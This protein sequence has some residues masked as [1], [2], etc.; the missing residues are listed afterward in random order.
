MYPDLFGINNSSFLILIAAGLL[1]AVLLFKFICG[2][3]VKD[4]KVYNY[5]AI[6][7]VVSIAVGLVFA[8]IFQSV[9]N[10]IDNGFTLFE[11]KGA[12]FYGGLIGGAATFIIITALAKPSVK[13]EFW[14]IANLAAP[15]IVIGHMFGRIGCFMA[16]CCYGKPTDSFLGVTFPHIGKVFPTQL[17]EV[18]FLLALFAVMMVLI[19]KYKKL[20]FIMLIYAY[21]YA[22]FRFFIEFLRN[23]SRGDFLPWLSPSQWQSI[24][25]LIVAA[26][27]TFYIYYFKRIPFKGKET[28]VI[29]QEG[30]PKS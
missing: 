27:L 4:D 12:T 23:D 30:V 16:G 8:M 10:W 15:C 3:F 14:L 11:F 9:Y 1:I 6:N 2:K 21:S 24:L 26:A 13:K 17:F 20:N 22:I 29:E 28:T 7:A 5:Y 25:M 19:F 18:F